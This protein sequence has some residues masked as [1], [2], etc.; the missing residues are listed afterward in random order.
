MSRPV[1]FVIDNDAGVVRA[2]SVPDATSS[3][4]ERIRRGGY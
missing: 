2:L 4:T 3:G 1:L